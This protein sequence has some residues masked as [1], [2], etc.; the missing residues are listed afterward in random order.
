MAAILGTATPYGPFNA[1]TWQEEWVRGSRAVH[2]HVQRS[3]FRDGAWKGD[4]PTGRVTSTT[5]MT[6]PIFA[7]GR[8][9]TGATTKVEVPNN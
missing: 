9:A 6:R 8:L 4:L 2:R 1:Y 5:Q 3:D 7:G